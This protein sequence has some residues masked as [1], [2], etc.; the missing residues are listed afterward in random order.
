MLSADELEFIRNACSK[1]E[2]D[3]RASF[4]IAAIHRILP[5]YQVY[6]EGDTGIRGHGPS[7]DALVEISRLLRRRPGVSF[8]LVGQKIER[9]ES[10]LSADLSRV[11]GLEDFSLSASLAEET[12]GALSLVFRGW[13]RADLDC[14]VKASLM[15]LEIDLIWAEGCSD[16]V[17]SW[18]GLITQY[19]WQ[20]RDLKELTSAQGEIAI[21]VYRTIA[22]RAEREGVAYLERMRSLMKHG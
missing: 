21:G 14:Y 7:H 10:G 16:A 1:L 20:V 13:K 11:R 6:S 17:V 18:D 8:E 4:V 5:V 9:A 19:G 22:M 15:A 3:G 12:M 2:N